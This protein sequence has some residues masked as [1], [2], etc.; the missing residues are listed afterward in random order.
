VQPRAARAAGPRR[1]QH[2]LDEAFGSH[3][4]RAPPIRAIDRLTKPSRVAT[5]AS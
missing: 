2:H 5:V 3:W 4:Q 1:I